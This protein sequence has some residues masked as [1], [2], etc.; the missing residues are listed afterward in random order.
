MGNAGSATL[1]VVRSHAVA[2]WRHATTPGRLRLAMGVLAA[3]AAGE[4]RRAAQNVT[5]SERRLVSA[6]EL[7]VTLSN[8]HATAAFSFLQGKP[9]APRSRHLYDD[10]LRHASVGV[11]DLAAK[12]GTSSDRGVALGRIARTLAVTSSPL[13]PS[14]RVAPRTS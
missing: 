5:V 11:A 8:T 1:K 12:T 2:G 3:H 10:E 9:E 13:V 4:G 6:V 14:P 7:S